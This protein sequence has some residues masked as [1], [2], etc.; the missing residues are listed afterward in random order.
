MVFCRIVEPPLTRTTN[1]LS[2]YPLRKLFYFK[3]E[4]NINCVETTH[5][6]RRG[7]Q[8]PLGSLYL[9]HCRTQ[10]AVVN[11]EVAALIGPP[12]LDDLKRFYGEVTCAVFILRN[13]VFWV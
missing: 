13:M 9:W 8:L 6:S 10:I 1:Q 4:T 3:V 7:S 11:A 12:R 5:T 2:M